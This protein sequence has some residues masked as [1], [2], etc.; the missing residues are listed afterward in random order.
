MEESFEGMQVDDL[1]D[2]EV[3][4]AGPPKKSNKASNELASDRATCQSYYDR[5]GKNDLKVIFAMA[6]GLTKKEGDSDVPLV[7]LK[8]EPYASSNNKKAFDP[9]AAF[10]I[11][12]VERRA[13]LLKEKKRAIP[14]PS[15]WTEAQCTK[16][17][18]DHPI[19]NEDDVKFVKEQIASYTQKLVL[20]STE[21]SAAV[22]VKASAAKKSAAKAV[23]S[24]KWCGNEPYLRLYHAILDD[25]NKA[26]FLERDFTLTKKELDARK[27]PDKKV[28]FWDSVATLYNDPTF[29]PSTFAWPDLHASFAESFVLFE[30]DAPTPVTPEK[31]RKKFADCRAKM[32]LVIS[33][34]EKSGNGD[35]MPSGEGSSR[36]VEARKKDFCHGK[37][38]RE[39]VLYLWSLLE[40]HGDSLLQSAVAEL[41]DGMWAN[42]SHIPATVGMAVRGKKN[43]TLAAGIEDAE[44]KNRMMNAS[45]MTELAITNTNHDLREAKKT[46]GDYLIQQSRDPHPVF[47]TLIDDQKEMVSYF[48]GKLEE[49]KQ[50]MNHYT[51]SD[52]VKGSK[53]I[54]PPVVLFPDEST[55]ESSPQE[56]RKANDVDDDDDDE[57][58]EEDEGNDN[59]EG[60]ESDSEGEED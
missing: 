28:W 40:V 46:L 11:L 39:H 29:S 55:N 38:Y 10:K 7:D 43:K 12:E 52:L 47:E 60:G 35:G 30:A 1:V 51:V 3:V 5:E 26:A 31:L 33:N 17:L 37:G 59:G 32:V 56:G 50:K 45:L 9:R 49:L 34:F 19:T 48:Q 53:N 13:L 41:P 58:E 14:R 18:C 8:Q 24:V 23:A 27:G 22:V 4:V 42:P 54:G 57:E 6:C 36:H 25:K 2:D 15:A 44:E 21:I 20:A 16:W